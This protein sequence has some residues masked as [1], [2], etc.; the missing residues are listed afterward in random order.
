MFTYQG[1]SC[2]SMESLPWRFVFFSVLFCFDLL[3]FDLIETERSVNL[4]VDRGR[5][6]DV[7][8]GA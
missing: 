2:A 6:K 5:V 1:R 7:F 8:I 3:P 4:K